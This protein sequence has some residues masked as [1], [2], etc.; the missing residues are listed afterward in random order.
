MG[1]N[2]GARPGAGRKPQEAKDRQQCHRD[3]V[4]D[5]AEMVYRHDPDNGAL[6]VDIP[7]L[8]IAQAMVLAT[9][10]RAITGDPI[11]F[12]QLFPYIA[13]AKPK[14]VVHSGN[15]D[16]RTTPLIWPSWSPPQIITGTATELPAPTDTEAT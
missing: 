14:E 1:Q 6:V 3:M 5:L 7:D 9:M 8:T 15:L 12:G 10:K 4:L 13:G 16:L 2:G 11:A